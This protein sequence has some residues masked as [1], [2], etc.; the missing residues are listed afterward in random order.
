[1]RHDNATLCSTC[2]ITGQ[3]SSC[4]LFLSLPTTDCTLRLDVRGVTANI[5]LEL[6][7]L[8][9]E[10][11]LVLEEV[12]GVEF[13]RGWILAVLLDVE[14]DGS[15]RG[16]GAR[17]T[18]DDAAAAREARVQALARRDGA[19]EVR[20][21]EVAGIGDGAVA[22]LGADEARVGDEVLEG[23]DDLVGA[24]R[25]DVLVVVAREEGAAVRLPEVQLDLLDA[26]LG[27]RVGLAQARDDVQPRH[28]GPHAVLLADV[29]A[30]R[31]EAFLA[32]D[33]EL[34]RVEERAEELPPR[35]H[36]VAVETLGLGDE[37]DG[38]RCGHAAG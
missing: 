36:L 28:D 14:A 3:L 33:A 25:V 27:A 8:G 26:G 7:K 12:L 16:A 24:V 29:V 22:D 21:R 17:K 37:V 23:A 31:A 15:A 13:V 19:V 30:A 38:T 10:L 35:R 6:E 34:V 32:A 1:M 2:N 4:F 11:D 20:V 18:D 9:G 5:L